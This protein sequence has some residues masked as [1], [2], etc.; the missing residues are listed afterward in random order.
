MNGGLPYLSV[1]DHKGPLIY[2]ID[3]TGLAFY[4]NLW[5]GVWIIEFLFIFLSLILGFTL[6]NQLYGFLPAIIGSISWITILGF[7]IGGGN[8]TEEYG[9][10]FQF[11]I[12]YLFYKSE[13]G[14]DNFKTGYLLMGVATG[15]IFL[16]KPNLIGISLTI[17]IYLAAITI[18]YKNEVTSLKKI[19]YFVTGFIALIVPF[20]IIF[21]IQGN[22][23]DFIDQF[24]FYNIIYSSSDLF[25][26][27]LAFKHLVSAISAFN[28]V[29]IIL[30]SY[31]FAIIV[32][33]QTQNNN[34]YKKF[35]IIL[36]IN[37][38]IEFV[39]ISYSGEQYKHYYMSLLPIISIF[40]G[41]FVYSIISYFSSFRN[42][43]YNELLTTLGKILAIVLI[44]GLCITPYVFILIFTQ[45]FDCSNIL[46]TNESASTA[47]YE[48]IYLTYSKANIHDPYSFEIPFLK[49]RKSSIIQNNSDHSTIQFI[50]ENT[51]KEDFVLMFGAESAINF[52]TQRKSP[53]RYV[54]QYPLYMQ[55]YDNTKKDQEF[56][57]DLAKNPPKLIIITNNPKTPFKKFSTIIKN[58]TLVANNRDWKIYQKIPQ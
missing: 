49:S 43:K 26:K 51:T 12:L 5:W 48:Y 3:A 18:I 7:F 11:I 57:S 15:L 14:K 54:Y 2:Y 28:L 41:F 34:I 27:V 10:L 37:L 22:F 42:S 30:V 50:L 36:L 13:C 6:L 16:L 1:W 47:K 45:F 33:K 55:G 52:I 56:L 46:I 21:F 38:P 20:C 24:F 58:Y 23:F 25:S 19:K 39:L 31:I 35:L 4:Q 17:L 53:T 8:F 44:F 32:I 40:I 29:F 9:I